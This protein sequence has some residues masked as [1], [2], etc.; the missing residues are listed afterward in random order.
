MTAYR[1]Y[2]YRI[3]VSLGLR[4]SSYTSVH[5]MFPVDAKA[6]FTNLFWSYAILLPRDAMHSANYA[7]AR[8]PS[9]TRRYS[10]EKVTQI[11]TLFHR[12]VATQVQSNTMWYEKN[13]DFRPISR[14][15]SEI[16]Q[17]KAIVTMK[18]NKEPQRIKNHTKAFEWYQFQ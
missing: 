9:V 13:H 11:L 16:M 18:A 1:L 4:P 12:W 2:Q 3:S 10:V 6:F 15:I 5:G 17:D 7:V 14:F 8:C